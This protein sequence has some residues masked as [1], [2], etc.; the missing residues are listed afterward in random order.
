M[1]RTF[2]RRPAGRNGQIRRRQTKQKNVNTYLWGRVFSAC[3]RRARLGVGHLEDFDVN[4][5]R[6]SLAA[7]R[8]RRRRRW[9]AEK[10]TNPWHRWL[11]V[12]TTARPT[13]DEYEMGA[14]HRKTSHRAG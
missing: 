2:G 5:T 3:A 9:S 6:V 4:S 7:D 11:A 1:I 8:R 13:D 10:G 12:L 14:L